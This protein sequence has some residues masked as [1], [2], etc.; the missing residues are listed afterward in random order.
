MSNMHYCR[1]ENTLDDLI[2]CYDAMLEEDM[3]ELSENEKKAKEQL[4]KICKKIIELTEEE[5]L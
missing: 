1:F 5:I 3:N 2:D 4:I